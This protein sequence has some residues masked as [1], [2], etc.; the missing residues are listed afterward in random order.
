MTSAH[1]LHTH[2]LGGPAFFSVMLINMESRQVE[3][4]CRAPLALYIYEQQAGEYRFWCK[5]TIYY[6]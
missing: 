2:T 3:V 1:A 6:I 5:K 4:M